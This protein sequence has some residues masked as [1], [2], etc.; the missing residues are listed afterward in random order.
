MRQN[1]GWQVRSQLNVGRKG[2]NNGPHG[3][4][5]FGE[6][7]TGKIDPKLQERSWVKWTTLVQSSTCRSH[8]RFPYPH[9]PDK[10]S[11]F[12]LTTGLCFTPEIPLSSLS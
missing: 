2:E 3:R 7:L 1:W 8:L 12:K 11:F 6:L 9:P 4:D 10:G 5:R